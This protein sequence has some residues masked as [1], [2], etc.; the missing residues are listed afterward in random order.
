MKNLLIALVLLCAASLTF[1]EYKDLPADVQKNLTALKKYPKAS[2]I[3][4]WTEEDYVLRS[5]GSKTYESHIFRYLPDEA[6]RD[7]FGDP[8]VNYAVG[9]DSLMILTARTYTKDGRTIDCTPNNAFNPV[10]PDGLDKAPDYASYRQMVITLMGLENGC[11]SEVHYRVNTA[12]PLVPWLENRIYFRDE[13]PIISHR[14]MV[15]IPDGQTL[16]YKVD[17][18]APEPSVSGATYTWTVSDQAGFNKQDLQGHRVLL[19]NVAFTSAKSWEQIQGDLK[20]RFAAASVDTLVI[21]AS[22]TKALSGVS[23]DENRLDAIKAWAK[24]RFNRNE[25]DHPDFALSLRPCKNVLSSGYGNGLELAALVC[26]L[27]NQSGVAAQV[28]PCFVPDA[29]VPYVHEIS[30]AVVA[31]RAPGG[32][33]SY[34]DPL[35]PCTE[36]GSADLLGYWLVPLDSKDQPFEFASKIKNPA[37]TVSLVLEDLNQDTLKGTGTFSAQGEFGAYEAVRE[38]GPEAMLKRNLHIKGLTITKATVKD[39]ESSRHGSNVNL[40]FSFTA[41]HALDTLDRYHVLPLSIIPFEHAASEAP[42]SLTTREFRQEVR[43]PITATFHLEA[44]IP[45]SWQ[46]KDMPKNLTRKWDFDEGSV[47]AEVK[48]GRL[49]FE[50]TLKLAK[51]W[52]PAESWSAFRTFMLDCGPRPD[53]AVVFEPKEIKTAKK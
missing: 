9:R 8:R 35:L 1:A 26:K 13:N 25:F 15:Q 27:A 14:L 41:V 36:F 3:V 50:R 16:T 46:V 34:T 17:R 24:V 21:P 43:S 20:A 32:V 29:P 48:D 52:I 10:G 23:G 53:N 28:V 18:G 51:D 33:Y 44:V 37:I 22:L 11:I 31:L 30:R 45:D 6:A 42:L 7:N 39:L 38:D 19:P 40:D 4:L 47:K 12:K 5:D 49:T 2:S